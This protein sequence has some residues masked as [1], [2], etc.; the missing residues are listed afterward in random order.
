M[1]R[2]L[3]KY[4]TETVLF[5]ISKTKHAVELKT[6]MQV[7]FFNVFCLMKVTTQMLVCFSNFDFL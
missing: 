3:K 4:E 2:S 5:S 6:C 7:H 1:L